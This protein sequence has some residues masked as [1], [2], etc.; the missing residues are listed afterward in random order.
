[1]TS[2]GADR[3][4]GAV[5]SDRDIYTVMVRRETGELLRTEHSEVVSID[6]VVAPLVAVREMAELF[7]DDLIAVSVPDGV[8]G[9]SADV[10]L[11]AFDTEL[12]GVLLVPSTA[13]LVIGAV[14]D[15]T[16]GDARTVA[17]VDVGANGTAVIVV[18]MSDGEVLGRSQIDSFG[19]HICDE[20][21]VGYLESRYG[22]IALPREEKLASVRGARRELGTHWAATV[23]GPFAR[24][25]TA[26][27]QVRLHR[28]TADLALQPLLGDFAEEVSTA[29]RRAHPDLVIG[30]GDAMTLNVVRRAV[31]GSSPTTFLTPTAQP[32]AR[33][34]A[35]V[36][37]S[38]TIGDFDTGAVLPPMQRPVLAA[39]QVANAA[40]AIVHSGLVT[41][42]PADS[43][44]AGAPAA[45]WS[46]S[47]SSAAASSVSGSSVPATSASVTSASGSSGPTSWTNPAS[48]GVGGVAGAVATVAAAL[49]V[50]S[51]VLV[52]AGNSGSPVAAADS[53]ASG[54]TSDT[55]LTDRTE[56]TA[57]AAGEYTTPLGVLPAATAAGE[58]PDL[59]GHPVP[60]APAPAE[61]AAPGPRPTEPDR[62]PTPATSASGE[63]QPSAP[64][65]TPTGGGGTGGGPQPTL[66]ATTVS[67]PTSTPVEPTPTST[68]TPT[69][70]P[71]TTNPVEPTTTTTTEV[72]PPV[73]PLVTS[74]ESPTTT[75]TRTTPTRTKERPGALG[76]HRDD[77]DDDHNHGHGH[78]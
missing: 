32:T 25:T 16:I 29:L 35:W 50:A 63:P 56:S 14:L 72:E 54:G 26:D 4:F 7:G 30:A 18:D 58:R 59:R 24:A 62:T 23:P 61:T 11:F 68:P 37:G 75:P 36:V 13:A 9:E 19:G 40:E 22:A 73:E 45:A 46:V 42:A 10:D 1:M 2:V 55:S 66:T 3:L 28:S 27:G 33:G 49:C 67:Q 41:T 74:D 78:R 64:P 5:V 12:D 15:G 31:A 71:T 57:P 51:V 52:N 8:V 6:E 39:A 44:V 48:W 20:T 43:A 76:L 70:T 21:L 60:T 34:V 53:F 17:V 69:P 77:D 47:G 38:R 65:N